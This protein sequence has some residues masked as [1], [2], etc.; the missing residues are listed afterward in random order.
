MTLALGLAGCAAGPSESGPSLAP[1]W[2]EQFD[3]ALADDGLSDFERQVLSDYQVTEAEYQEA[4]DRYRSC[5]A[6]QG[7]LVTDQSDGGYSIVSAPGNTQD[8]PP[9]PQVHNGC[10]TGSTAWIEPLYLGPRDNPSGETRV[11]Q[12]RA[13]F[14][15]HDVPDG[16]GL[17]DDQFAEMLYDINYHPSTP[18]GKLCL[19]DPTGSEGMTV[20]QAEAMDANNNV[21]RG[22][23]NEDGTITVE[24]RD[25]SNMTVTPVLV[26]G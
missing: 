13:C 25:G 16:A 3:Q 19:F 5:M 8:P 18:Q 12:I 15:A 7:W 1:I 21:A 9:P 14:Q 20:E 23:I 6:D 11:Q 10:M 24:Y 26:D 22:T 17:S 4:R 2:Q